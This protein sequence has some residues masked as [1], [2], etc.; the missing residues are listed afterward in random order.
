MKS[1]GLKSFR[2]EI[3]WYSLLSL[4]YTVITEALL[5]L[6]FYLGALMLKSIPSSGDNAYSN[7][8][9]ESLNKYLSL[10]KDSTVSDSIQGI[11]KSNGV[12]TD[13]QIA[14]Y[15]LL[16]ILLAVIVGIVLFI[17]YF[18]LLTKRFTDYLEEIA[19]GIN[20]ITLGDLNYRI[21]IYKED[22][23]ALVA[24]KINK[25]AAEI[26]MMMESERKSESTKNDLIT[27]V[28]HDLRTPLTSIIGYLELALKE[29]RIEYQNDQ[30][31][32]MEL[33]KKYMD[34]AYQKSRRLE[35]LIE[36]LFTYTKFSF[37]EVTLKK[38]EID[39][40]KFMDQLIEEFY[41][42]F[43]EYGLEY[44]FTTNVPSAVILADGDLLARAFANLIGNAVKYGKDGK[45]VRI[46]LYM[47][48]LKVTVS[49][50]NYGE[51]IPQKDI[52]N[53][54][55]RFYRVENSRSVETGG[56]GLGLAIAKSII[57]MHGGTIEARSDF[58]GT[59][60]EVAFTFDEIR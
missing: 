36:D 42:S 3:V 53:I 18:L 17:T 45:K 12:F 46:K 29:E 59:V 22:E 58:D 28:A 52:E 32:G 54:F 55:D 40:V 26:G 24:S 39:L 1:K 15:L 47:D 51:L 48:A 2:Y 19:V 7:G 13:H 50:I 34:I 20:E 41:P 14:R 11:D 25:M 31:N 30:P 43:N 5:F 9:I 60:F 49:I 16:F 56:A 8:K 44:D 6:F 33:K 57:L 10:H 21:P 37:G 4:I 27:S 35:K 38:T 23:F